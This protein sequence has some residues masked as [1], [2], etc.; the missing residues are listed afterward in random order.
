METISTN[1]KDLHDT[2]MNQEDRWIYKDL[3]DYVQKLIK[4]YEG[5]ERIF[6]GWNPKYI[7]KGIVA[8]LP[9]FGSKDKDDINYKSYWAG[10]LMW[11]Y[12]GWNINKKYIGEDLRALRKERGIGTKRKIAHGQESNTP[13]SG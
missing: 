5:F 7:T 9:D 8:Y 6:L 2:P 13:I 11:H 10:K 1:Q 4:Q 3:P 12:V